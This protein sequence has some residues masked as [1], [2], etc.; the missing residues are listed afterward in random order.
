MREINAVC[1]RPLQTCEI[2]LTKPIGCQYDTCELILY[3]RGHATVIIFLATV[4]QTAMLTHRGYSYL[5]RCIAFAAVPLLFIVINPGLNKQFFGISE[6]M[7]TNR[8][9]IMVS[10]ALAVAMVTPLLIDVFLDYRHA[11][12]TWTWP[13]M[14][15]MTSVCFT[16]VCLLYF[17]WVD[18]P[19]P[20]FVAAQMLLSLFYDCAAKGALVSALFSPAFPESDLLESPDLYFYANALIMVLRLVMWFFPG[21]PFDWTTALDTGS[22]ATQLLFSLHCLLLYSSCPEGVSFSLL[23]LMA[24]CLEATLHNLYGVDVFVLRTYVGVFVA[25]MGSFM[26]KSRIR[27]NHVHIKD[28]LIAKRAFVRYIAH[29]MRTPLNVSIIGVEMALNQCSQNS[30]EM[31]R[32]AEILS[33]ASQSLVE[34]ADT[35]N[36][37]LMIDKIQSGSMVLDKESFL[38]LPL[39]QEVYKSFFLQAQQKNLQYVLDVQSGMNGVV[40]H[41]DKKKVSQSMRNYI[42]NALKFTPKDGCVT[43]RVFLLPVLTPPVFRFEVMDS[44]V[45]ISASNLPRIFREVVQFDAA[46]LQNGGGSGLGLTI[47]KAIVEAHGGTVDVLSCLGEGSTFSLE[48]DT[49]SDLQAFLCSHLGDFGGLVEERICDEWSDCSGPPSNTPYASPLYPAAVMGRPPAQLMSRTLS[50]SSSGHTKSDPD[51]RNDHPFLNKV[52]KIGVTLLVDDSV[53]S[54]KMMKRMCTPFADEIIMAEN[55]QEAAEIVESSLRDDG[56]PIDVVL[57]DCHMPILNG[58]DMTARIRAAGYRGFVAMV[59]G[60]S[61]DVLMSSF[62]ASGGNT[63]LTKPISEGVIT[64]MFVQVVQ[65]STS[66]SKAG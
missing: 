23:S 22:L 18:V 43:V 10:S 6:Q 39:V 13:R 21:C 33:D 9:K 65:S 47:T 41:A 28:L 19:T 20:R 57:T 48:L 52:A 31:T 61:D 3:I 53:M 8:D 2:F 29:E 7:Q 54:M 30:V 63:I 62:H 24:T 32:L 56:R 58:I 27:Q 49:D 16:N 46:K 66:V 25:L 15:L 17:I 1:C 59:S 4:F 60:D 14:A 38:V 36:E 45:G 5:A 50:Q 11:I 26:A 51:H 40:L 42:S 64:R 37:F 44:G 34:A 35:L 12:H 55:G